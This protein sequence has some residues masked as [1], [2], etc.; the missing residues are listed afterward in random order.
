MKHPKH[1]QPKHFLHCSFHART[2]TPTR[3]RNKQQTKTLPLLFISSLL[4]LSSQSPTRHSRPPSPQNTKQKQKQTKK[5]SSTLAMSVS[6]DPSL[7]PFSLAAPSRFDLNTYLGRVKHF[8]NTTDPTTLLQPKS[9]VLHTQHIASQPPHSPVLRSGGVN[10]KG[11]Q[12]AVL[13]SAAAPPPLFSSCSS[14]LLLLL[15]LLLFTLPPTSFSH[16]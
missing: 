10:G 9:K 8:Y 1:K 13:V 12:Q 7:P 2:Q 3:R 11:G 14:P 6:D 16:F 5:E 15:P 4:P